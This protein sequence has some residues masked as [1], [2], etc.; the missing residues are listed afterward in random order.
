M[1]KL[2]PF[3]ATRGM[4][5]MVVLAI[6]VQS[7]SEMGHL[8]VRTAMEA[9]EVK[10]VP[11][12]CDTGVVMVTKKNIDTAAAKNVLCWVRTKFHTGQHDTPFVR[13]S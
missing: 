13:H 8:G 1:L 7:A 10:K 4:M 11:S 9:A 5:L 3:I 12:F 2:S 6:A